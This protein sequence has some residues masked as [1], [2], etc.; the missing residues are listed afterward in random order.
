[1]HLLALS[2]FRPGQGWV[3]IGDTDASQCTFWC[4]VLSD[5]S[6]ERGDDD[7]WNVSMHLLVLGAFRPWR[8]ILLH[9]AFLWSQYTFW[10]LVLSDPRR[11]GTCRRRRR[12]QCTFW[13]LVLSDW[14]LPYGNTCV[15]PQSQCTFWCLV[16]SDE[17][18]GVVD[19]RDPRRVS[20]H[21]LVLG[22]FRQEMTLL[23]DFRW[24]SQCTFWCLVLSDLQ[25]FLFLLKQR[26]VSMHLL[27][28]GAFRPCRCSCVTA[29]LPQVSMHLLVLGAFRPKGY[30]IDEV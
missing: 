20:M 22:A 24:E 23:K 14:H 15:L 26:M 16:L 19:R 6:V 3:L 7:A 29:P 4:S 11:R 17:I 12:S 21:L 18:C 27:V 28:L 2:A 30:R 10:C 1:M 13:C 5:P 25:C 9:S 8:G